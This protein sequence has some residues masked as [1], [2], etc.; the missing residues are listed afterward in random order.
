MCNIAGYVGTKQAAPILL[1]M[2]KKEEG[3]DAGYYAG[4][5]T[6][7]SGKIFYEKLVGHAQMLIEQK[8][9]LALPGTIGI[10]HGRS[11]GGGGQG[12]A[13]PFVTERKNEIISAYIANGNNAP[14]SDLEN[15][16]KITD[17]LY[18]KGY[19]MKSK[20]SEFPA[21]KKL[22]Y[23][24]LP[25]TDTV[26]ISDVMCQL[27]TMHTDQ[28]LPP[29]SA[30]EKAF[31]EMPSEL[32]G[33]YLHKDAPTSIAFAR[34]NMPMF[35]AYA[36]HGTYIASTPTAFPEDAGDPITILP[37]SY[38]SIAYNSLTISSFS[39][40]K[41]KIAPIDARL[42]YEAYNA[43]CNLLNEGPQNFT[44]LKKAVIPFFE[45]ADVL[46]FEAAVYEVLYSLQKQGKIK[47]EP[48]FSPGPYGPDAPKNYVS[49]L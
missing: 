8:N 19:E 20:T 21:T 32:V 45:E 27:I 9:A 36:E 5:A 24:R 48:V 13:H 40:K 10:C 23:P 41:G 15:D 16:A 14:F 17:M 2:M 49:F 39:E 18:C 47:I 12:F 37:Y 25:D 30:M 7:D 31:I 6:M 42:R 44:A 1:E 11:R 34:T 3:F 22:N 26:H 4:I 46:Q 33:L 29:S 28:G 43:I 35:V 38:G